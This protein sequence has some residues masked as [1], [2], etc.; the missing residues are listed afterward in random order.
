M[1]CRSNFFRFFFLPLARSMAIFLAKVDLK[2]PGIQY[3]RILSPLSSFKMPG[4]VAQWNN[5]TTNCLHIY[6][7]NPLIT[8]VLSLFRCKVILFAPWFYELLA[9]SYRQNWIG[10]GAGDLVNDLEGWKRAGGI[11]EKRPTATVLKS[12]FKPESYST[13]ERQ[14]QNCLFNYI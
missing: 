7:F 9:V 6:L 13:R 5:Q 12:S 4:I 10:K 11:G 3:T 8:S 1:C 14:Y 2:I